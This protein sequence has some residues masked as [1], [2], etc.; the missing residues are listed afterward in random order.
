MALVRLNRL[1]ICYK[2]PHG[3]LVILIDDLASFYDNHLKWQAIHRGVAV[4]YKLVRK[5]VNR[6]L[7]MDRSI[8]RLNHT[9][10]Y[11]TSHL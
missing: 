5:G 7:S 8:S 6:G 11:N 1:S 10:F 2:P 9:H 3:L 4:V